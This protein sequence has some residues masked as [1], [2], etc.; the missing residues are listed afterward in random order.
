MPR[1][2]HSGCG[3]SLASAQGLFKR[4][5]AEIAIKHADERYNAAFQI[6]FLPEDK[7]EAIVNYWWVELVGRSYRSGRGVPRASVES[8]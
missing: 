1:L 4:D 5:E 2:I 3:V 6:R 7:L 8:K